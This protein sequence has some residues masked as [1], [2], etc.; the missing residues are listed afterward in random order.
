MSEPTRRRCVC[1]GKLTHKWHRI[2]GGPW[3]CFDG[4]YSTTGYDHRDP[5]GIPK[6]F[7][8]EQRQE[9]SKQQGIPL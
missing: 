7:S 1:C 5:Q 4:C 8:K 9:L 3:H 2:N 6:W